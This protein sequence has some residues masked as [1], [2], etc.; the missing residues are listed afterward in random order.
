MGL[1]GALI[2]QCYPGELQGEAVKHE[3]ER[4][5]IIAEMAARLGM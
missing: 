2:H 3:S 4:Y 1:G 5:L